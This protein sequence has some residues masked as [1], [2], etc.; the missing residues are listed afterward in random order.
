AGC[1]VVLEEFAHGFLAAAIEAD[2]WLI[3]K[4]YSWTVQHLCDQFHFHPLAETKFPHHHIELLAHIEH[5]RQLAHDPFKV[6][7][8]NSIN[9]AVQFERLAGGRVPPECVLLA[10]QEADLALHGILAFPRHIAE[11]AGSSGGGVE[12]AGKHFQG[13]GFSGAVW[14]EKPDKIALSNLKG[15]TVHGPRLGLFAME[16]SFKGA[17]DPTFLPIRAKRLGESTKV[18]GDVVIVHARGSEAA[19]RLRKGRCRPRS[20]N[21]DCGLPLAWESSSNGWRWLRA[22]FREDPLSRVRRQ[23]N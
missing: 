20:P 23:G 8:G 15:D 3:E 12:Q 4:K 11:N 22:S 7:P 14:A 2:S 1:V 10:H 6:F 17:E 21:L 9:N 13:C 19:G 5:L 18:N 16:K